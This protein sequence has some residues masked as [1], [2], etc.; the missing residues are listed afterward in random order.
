MKNTVYTIKTY[1][2]IILLTI[3]PKKYLSYEP[4]E[5]K[6]TIEIWKKKKWWYTELK[7]GGGRGGK[8]QYFPKLHEI[9][10]NRGILLKKSKFESSYTLQEDCHY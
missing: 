6:K 1:E 9:K 4:R 8:A 7:M 2:E 10:G 5:P 3:K